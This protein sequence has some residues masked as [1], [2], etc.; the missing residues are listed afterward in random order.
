M[1][2]EQCKPAYVP[3]LGA[4]VRA[5]P[6]NMESISERWDEALKQT[7]NFSTSTSWMNGAGE[8]FSRVKMA[9]HIYSDWKRNKAMLGRKQS[10][11]FLWIS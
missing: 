10:V 11:V 3:W 5:L 6:K 1:I 9:Y 2:T 8:I 4:T 7:L